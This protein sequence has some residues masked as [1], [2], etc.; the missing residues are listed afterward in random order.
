MYNMPY[1]QKQSDAAKR[2]ERTAS[3]A[4]EKYAEGQKACG[5]HRKSQHHFHCYLNDIVFVHFRS[6]STEKC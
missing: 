1:E 5:F 2:A 3:E 4:A 6:G